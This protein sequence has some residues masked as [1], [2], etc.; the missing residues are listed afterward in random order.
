M[1]IINFPQ[2]WWQGIVDIALLNIENFNKVWRSG[3]HRYI[4]KYL[5]E[6]SAK[7]EVCQSLPA[8]AFQTLEYLM[9]TQVPHRNFY[10]EYL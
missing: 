7:C 5:R 9:G 1:L 4:Q 3:L 6:S 8:P 2:T 10:F